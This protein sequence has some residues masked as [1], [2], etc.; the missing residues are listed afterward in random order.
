MSTELSIAEPQLKPRQSRRIEAGVVNSSA[1]ATLRNRAISG[2]LWTIGGYGAGQLMRLGSNLVL[3]RLLYP[4]AFGMMA[5]VYTLI[6]GLQMLSDVGISA[7]IIRSKDLPEQKFINTAWTLQVIRGVLLWLAVCAIA[8]PFASIYG[9]PEL[10]RIL[11]VAGLTSVIGGFV[12]AKIPLSIRELALRDM[13][14]FELCTQAASLCCLLG[15]TM[16]IGSLWALV[17]GELTGSA[18]RVTLSY[19]MLSGPRSR[20]QLDRESLRELLL[21]GRWVFA[22]TALFFLAGQVDRILLGSVLTLSM[23]GVYVVALAIAEMPKSVLAKLTERVHYPLVCAHA[24]D[25]AKHFATSN[26]R[27]R[28]PFL[29]GGAIAIAGSVCLGDFV[30][31]ILYDDRYADG[32][33]MLPILAL[34][35]WPRVASQ[36]TCNALL[37][38]GRPSYPAIGNAL[39]FVF[40]LPAVTLG[41]MAYEEAGAISA[42][43]LGEIP[44]YFSNLVGAHSFRLSTAVQ[45]ARATLLLVALIATGF[46]LR[47]VSGAGLPTWF[48]WSTMFAL[49]LS[50]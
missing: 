39:K 19:F 3:T 14:I 38:L 25:D 7:S 27:S 26:A 1:G 18:V 40:T 45:D 5:L 31:S 41:Y 44:F 50:N 32:R 43:A 42:V 6:V 4:E 9:Q 24:A 28:S 49:P 30:I 11:P 33:W 20:L 35:A 47:S 37:A 16:V 22:S 34:S 36:T 23:F 29:I 10:Q 12:S 21:F 46:A 2:S 17:I 15:L 8:V 13:T 48:N